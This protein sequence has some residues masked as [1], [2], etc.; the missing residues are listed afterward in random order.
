MTREKAEEMVTRAYRSVLGRDADAG[1][2]Q[3]YVQRVLR[4]HWSEADV[5]RDAPQQRRVPQ[6]AIGA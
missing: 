3:G 2:M 5:A 6:Q 1:G 4:D